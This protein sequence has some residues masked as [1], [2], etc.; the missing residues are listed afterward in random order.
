[1]FQLL[2]PPLLLQGAVDSFINITR[3]VAALR[4]SPHGGLDREV[5]C[6]TSTPGFGFVSLFPSFL[7]L[8]LLP[9][10]LTFR[11]TAHSPSFIHVLWFLVGKFQKNNF[12]LPPAGNC[13]EPSLLLFPNI[14]DVLMC[15]HFHQYPKSPYFPSL[16]PFLPFVFL[17]GVPAP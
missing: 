14:L 17:H 12:F 5:Q 11:H 3:S 16:S 10:P 6:S 8:S 9:T 15:V 2:Q 7:P 13:L 4:L 1:M